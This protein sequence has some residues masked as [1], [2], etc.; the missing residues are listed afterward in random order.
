[1]D[2]SISST[3]YHNILL[4]LIRDTIS[5]IEPLLEGNLALI[6]AANK[7][8]ANPPIIGQF[9]VYDLPD[10]D[11]AALA[12]NGELSAAN[13][14]V[15]R[16]KTEYIDVIRAKLQKYSDVNVVLV[17]E[18][19][20][21]AN[22]ITNLGVQKCA[23]AAANYREL[24]IYAIKQLALPNVTMYLDGGHGGWLGWPA[25]LALAGP[26]Y[27]SL[28]K[29]AGSPKQLRGFAVNV[30][31][32]NAWTITTCPAYTSPNVNCDEKRYIEAF[33]PALASAGWPDA[34]FI[35][36]TSRN[37]VQPT[38]Q[39]KQGN[40]C[41]IIGTGFGLRPGQSTG[42]SLLDSFVWIKP[43]GEADGTSDTSAV[44]YDATCGTADALKPAP[45]AGTWFQAYFEQLL[46]NSNPTFL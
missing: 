8:G 21:L 27:G 11:C 17:I 31:N 1:M 2:V 32:Y 18:P 6:S 24:T 14:G 36:D 30:S 10:R 15:A 13:G 35:M 42:S 26:Y 9:V 25:N 22:M 5:K 29:D 41:N 40:W 46:R 44:R 33:A 39:L 16:Y 34:H 38:A 37:G 20:S 28:Y 23:Q 43:G 3:T 19:D 7:A 45:E 4:T 12:S